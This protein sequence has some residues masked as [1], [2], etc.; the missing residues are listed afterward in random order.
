MNSNKIFDYITAK[1][2]QSRKDRKIS[3]L[4]LALILGHNSTSYVARI[5]LRKGGVNYNLLHLYLIANEFNM[6]V[7]DFLPTVSECG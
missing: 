7:S 6:E 3:Q 4:K 1:V 2:K 5:E